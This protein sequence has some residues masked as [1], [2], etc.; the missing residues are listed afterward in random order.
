MPTANLIELSAGFSCYADDEATTRFGYREIFEDDAYA[1]DDLPANP[2]VVDVGAGIGLFTLFVKRRYPA[3]KV[4]AFEPVPRNAALL[5]R[6]L[7]LHGIQDDVVVRRSCLGAAPGPDTGFTLVP[8]LAGNST[9]YPRELVEQRR[10]MAAAVG[11]RRAAALF[12]TERIPVEV[13]CFS[14]AVAGFAATG[15][16]DLVKVDVEGAEPDV[17]EGIADSDWPRIGAFVVEVGGARE[18]VERTLRE[19]GFAV[20]STRAPFMWPEL[21]I[22]N[23]TARR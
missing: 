9:L 3:A 21:G 16:I 20:R 14:P 10:L 19:R 6:N 8:N 7:A 13:E 11:E 12:A 22:Y 23:V 18:V 2:V 15:P 17:L 1:F 5:A 4:L